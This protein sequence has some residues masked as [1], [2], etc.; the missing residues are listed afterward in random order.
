[1]SKT[2]LTRRQFLQFSS[3]TL[4][5]GALAGC[6]L[7]RRGE[8][9]TPANYYRLNKDKLIQDLRPMAEAVQQVAADKYDP[10][11][12]QAWIDNATRRFD[13]MLPELPYIGGGSNDLTSNL[14]QSAYALALYQAMQAGGMTAE[15]T[16]ELLY[17]GVQRQMATSALMGIGGRMSASQLAQDKL[18]AEAEIS[19]RRTYPGDWVFEFVA[20]DGTFDYG[21]DYTEC[22]ICKYFRAQGGEA[23]IPYLC[24]LDFPM[25][26]AMNTGL[27]R[28]ITLGHGGNRCDFRYKYGRPVQME[29]TPEFLNE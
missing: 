13:G 22:G 29:W 16:G 24:L 3:L 7:L 21:I 8:P 23:F 14:Y 6:G 1:M 5:A 27:A 17:L 9:E 26:E 4:C 15:S 10:A 20:G 25:S 11:Q 18:K 28:T 12:A 19:Q 2:S